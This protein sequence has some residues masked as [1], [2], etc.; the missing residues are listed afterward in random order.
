MFYTIRQ[1][2]LR[3]IVL[4]LNEVS[5][6]EFVKNEIINQERLKKAKGLLDITAKKRHGKLL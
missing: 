5:P 2:H 6:V 1:L 4:V 3:I